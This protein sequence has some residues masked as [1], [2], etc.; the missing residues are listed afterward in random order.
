MV[1]VRQSN[2]G[3]RC[4]HKFF[5]RHVNIVLLDGRGCL[6]HIKEFSTL[7]RCGLLLWLQLL[8]KALYT[9]HHRGIVNK[10][11]SNFTRWYAR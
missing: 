3:T 2:H 1:Q 4:F 10:F 6:D 7:T 5:R 8:V 11:M 9:L